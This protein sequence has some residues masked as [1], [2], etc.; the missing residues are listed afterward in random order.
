MVVLTETTGLKS[1]HI[2]DGCFSTHLNLPEIVHY[3]KTSIPGVAV[4]LHEEFIHHY[5]SKEDNGC[6]ITCTKILAEKFAGIKVIDPRHRNRTSQPLPGEVEYE[7]R[8][9]VKTSRQPWGILYDGEKLQ[10]IYNA[11]LPQVE[12]GAHALHIVL[13]N[14]LFGTWGHDDVRFH[15][16]TSIYSMPGIISSTGLV[17]A[18]AK[19]RTYYVTRQL[20]VSHDL[21][22]KHLQGQFLTHDDSRLT[23]VIKGYIMQA[24]FYSLDGNPFCEDPN[25]RLY[26]AHWQH[27]LIHAQLNAPY[28]FC[29]EHTARLKSMAIV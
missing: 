8:R 11:L 1:I 29:H 20:G 27:E 19:S 12:R 6:E 3:L 26:N 17:E 25:C 15:A 14:Q 28:E 2:Y 24:V 7:E 16:R 13:T 18:P 21:L 9:L 23:E 5:T 10:E 22:E 4:C